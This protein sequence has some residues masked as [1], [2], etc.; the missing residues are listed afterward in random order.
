MTA[1]DGLE[2]GYRRLLRWFPREHRQRHG[3]EMLGVLLAAAPRG[4]RRPGI[5]EV[6]DLLQ[7][8]LRLR[9]RPG[10]ALSDQAGWRATLAMYSIAAP[11]VWTIATSVSYMATDW[12]AAATGIGRHHGAWWP[13]DP[14]NPWVLLWFVVDSQAAVAVLALLGL[15]R[16]AAAAA[17]IPLVYT[18]AKTV[19]LGGPPLVMAATFLLGRAVPIIEVLALLAS[20]GPRHGLRLM[21]RGHWALAGACALI[22]AG[23]FVGEDITGM[24]PSPAGA[25][26]L[27]FAEAGVLVLIVAAAWLTSSAGKRLAAIIAILSCSYWLALFYW[28]GASTPIPGYAFGIAFNAF[29]LGLLARLIYRRSRTRTRDRDG[30]GTT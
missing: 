20:A 16:W 1:T 14:A 10:R 12:W 18:T 21:H 29:I 27:T 2:A 11:V 7:S 23:I 17:A 3:E 9:L 13:Y 26:D 6:A 8:A 22:A 4:R 5:A 24:A 15:R 19:M 30:I 28:H 25:R